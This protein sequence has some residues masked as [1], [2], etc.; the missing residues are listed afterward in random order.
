MF[1]DAPRRSALA[2]RISARPRR[3]CGGSKTK[4]GPAARPTWRALLGVVVCACLTAEAQAQPEDAGWRVRSASKVR[5]NP[6]GF[7]VQPELAWRVPLARSDHRLLRG[8]HFETGLVAKISPASFHPGLYA[9]LVPISPIVLRAQ[10]QQL[11][12]FGL[13]GHLTEYHGLQPDWHPETREGG[14]VTGR[15]ATGW[16]ASTSATLRLKIGRYL[17]QVKTTRQWFTMDVDPRL[18]WYDSTSD[19]I[20]AQTDYLD[21]VDATLGAFL[22]GGPRD[23]QFLMVGG[24]WRGYRTGR[25]AL[26][27]QLMCGA[28]L[29]RPGWWADRKLTF[30]ALAGS[31]VADPYRRGQLYAGG[32]MVMTWDTIGR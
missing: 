13:F 6:I 23:V 21:R 15:H 31:Y 7:G 9:K 12:Y 17:A 10:V 28:L 27:R 19:L 24:Q 3:L 1:H 8:T 30:A 16:T 2:P 18:S 29:W 32:Q 20:Y 25:T 22:W 4:L 26:S 14:I 11:R 5:H